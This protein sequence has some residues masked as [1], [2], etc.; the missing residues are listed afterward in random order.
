ML[1]G[2]YR[3]IDRL[4]FGFVGTDIRGPPWADAPREFTSRPLVA[5]SRSQL[6]HEVGSG[7]C[8]CQGARALPVSALKTQ[9]DEALRRVEYEL[10]GLPF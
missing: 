8:H 7:G 4:E 3:I 6:A 1:T 9:L 5:P 2:R 10:L